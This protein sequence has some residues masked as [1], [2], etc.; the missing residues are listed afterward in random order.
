M[1][2]KSALRERAKKTTGSAGLVSVYTELVK[3]GKIYCVQQL[4]WTVDKTMSGGN[5]R[6]RLYIDGHGYNH[7]LEEQ[8]AP[9]AD[10]IYSYSEPVWL[11]PGE[12]LGLEL[13]QAQA[14]TTVEI[15]LTGYWTEFSEGIV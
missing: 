1:A 4:A 7:L 2:R 8:D 5:T 11:V 13:D 14:T 10:T 3:P 12:R 9:V 6:V 15:I